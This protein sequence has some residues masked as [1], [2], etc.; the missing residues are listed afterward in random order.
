MLEHEHDQKSKY[1]NWIRNVRCCGLPFECRL[2][3]HK[4]VREVTDTEDIP[5]QIRWIDF[6][7]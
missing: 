1:R 5:R 2:Q 4:P 3:L 7:H 6:S